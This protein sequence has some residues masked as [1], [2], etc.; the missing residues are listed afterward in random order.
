[1]KSSA[2]PARAQRAAQ[3]AVLG[4]GRVTSPLR[5]LPQFLICGV[6]RCGTTTMYRTLSQHPSIVKAV[7]HK[8]V[9]YFDT[10]YPN[11]QSWYQAHFPL[12]LTAARVTRRTHEPALTFESSP[13]YSFHPLAAT[14]IAHD[15]PDVR[16]I[17]LLRDPVERAYS[18]YTHELARGFETESFARALELEPSRLEGEE[19]RIIADPSY[20]S[21]SHQHQA[22]VT[23][24]HYLPQLLRWEQLV[25]RDRLH[26][27]DSDDFFIDP[28]P[29]WR[30][31]VSFLGLSDSVI[32]R[33]EQ[34][35]ARPRSAMPDA[36]R[37]QVREQFT[38]SDAALAS[39]WGQTPSWRR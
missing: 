33:F 13:Y 28:E 34:H 6:Q 30:S 38:E 8:G 17:V 27:V 22:Y 3:Q 32:P 25:G 7:L 23:R 1:M 18:A 19:E 9:H 21:H 31:T 16:I 4:F 36:L 11:G 14:R 35:N 5:M 37:A 24:G 10:G 39:W 20:N 2:V 15:L 12:R 26:V 29:T